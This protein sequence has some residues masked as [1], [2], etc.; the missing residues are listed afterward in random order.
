[1]PGKLLRAARPITFS[2]TVAA[3][4]ST[5][6]R[7]GTPQSPSDLTQRRSAGNTPGDLLALVQMQRA[8]I[9][10]PRSRRK[11]ALPTQKAKNSGWT[12]TQSPP[13]LAQALPLL[14]APPYLPLELRG[15]LPSTHATP[16]CYRWCC[17]DRLNAPEAI[18]ANE[19]APQPVL[20]AAVRALRPAGIFNRK[21]HA[22]M[23]VPQVH[24]RHRAAQGQILCAE[25][26]R[27][28]RVGCDKRPD[29]AC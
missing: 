11:T 1:M 16:S 9:A 12:P 8:D 3:Q 6:A 20:R 23:R 4:F 21:V 17:T 10:H 28:L 24:L 19:L 26:E 15:Y 29:G 2:A 27:A 14:P 22:R 18:F 7:R 25:L 5:D 13:D